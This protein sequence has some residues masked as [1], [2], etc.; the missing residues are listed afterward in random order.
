MKN[1]SFVIFK[2][3]HITFG[4]KVR[5]MLLNP[6]LAL[7]TLQTL[8][9]LVTRVGQRSNDFTSLDFRYFNSQLRVRRPQLRYSSEFQSPWFDHHSAHESALNSIMSFIN[10]KAKPTE[11]KKL[12]H[13]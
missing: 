4:F 7:V 12:L 9:S 8:Q 2:T 6:K 1:N 11:T 13:S 3:S 5:T 10:R